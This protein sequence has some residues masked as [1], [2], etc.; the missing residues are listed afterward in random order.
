[1]KIGVKINPTFE[2][3]GTTNPLYEKSNNNNNNAARQAH[4]Q[5]TEHFGNR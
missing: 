1:L 4:R 5:A 2:L 3:G